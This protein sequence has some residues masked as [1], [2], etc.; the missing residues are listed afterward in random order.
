MPIFFRTD[1]LGDLLKGYFFKFLHLDRKVFDTESAPMFQPV[2]RVILKLA[3]DFWEKDIP[4]IPSEVGRRRKCQL[5]SLIAGFDDIFADTSD[6][7]GILFV[8]CGVMALVNPDM[9]IMDGVFSFNRA[10]PCPSEAQSV[11]RGNGK[12]AGHALLRQDFSVR[13]EGCN[14][15][16]D[17]TLIAE[18]LHRVDIDVKRLTFD[19]QA[20]PNCLKERPWDVRLGDDKEL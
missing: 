11:M 15:T 4:V 2:E 17:W 16:L 7:V 3:L 9:Q 5:R 19:A 13:Q 20:V 1:I 18:V 12:Q 10:H 6:L 8:H 14:Q